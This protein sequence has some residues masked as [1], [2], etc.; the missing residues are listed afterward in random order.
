[1]IKYGSNFQPFVGKRDVKDKSD[2]DLTSEPETL[3][4]FR[5]TWELGIH[6]YLSYLRDRLLLAKDLLHISGSIFV[7]ISEEN[8]HLVRTLL[9]EIF[10]P[11]NFVS[12]I[13]YTT[14]G[15]FDSST[16]SRAGDYLLWYCKD[17]NKIKYRPLYQKK[18]SPVGGVSKYEQVE[19]RDGKRRP[20]TPEEKRGEKPLPEGS[21][22]F[23]LGDLTSQGASKSTV[24]QYKFGGR[25]HDC[26]PNNH[27]KTS[28]PEGMDKLAALKRITMTSTGKLAYV[29]YWDDFPY[30][31]YTNLWTDIGG[32]VQSRDKIYCVQ[33]GTSV[34]ER[35]ILMTTDPGDLIFDPTCGSGTTA[36][37]SE[38]WGRR[39][40]TCDTSRVAITLAKQRLMTAHYDYYKLARPSEGIDSGLVYKTAT[41][42]TL[43]SLA[44]GEAPDLVTL[45]DQPERDSKRARVTGPF[46]VEA[47][48]APVVQSLNDKLDL[49][50]NIADS[51]IG[52]AGETARQQDWREELLRSGIRGK[53]KRMIEFVRLEVLSGT[54]WL[55]LQ[56]EIKGTGERCFVS[57]GPEHAP[58]DQRQVE[59]AVQEAQKFVPRSAILIFAAFQFDPEAAKD[60]DELS[61]PGTE[62]LKAQMNPDLFT[63]DLKKKRS[64][65]ESFWLIG[66][67]DT[68]TQKIKSG[69]FK[70]MYEVVVRGFDYYNPQTGAIDSGDSGNIAMWMLDVDY[71][72]RSLFPRQVFFPNGG[73]NDGWKRLAKTL[74]SEIDEELI[75]QY[76]G[77]ISLPFEVGDYKRVAIK[78]V[79][80]RGI[81]SLRIIELQE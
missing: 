78:I 9:D 58:L 43:G 17:K 2:A 33:T 55:N 13:A 26:G 27:W 35:C 21:R 59:L 39:W 40:I 14:S 72:G 34:I 74:Q 22:L 24:R 56:G 70:G 51:S 45:Y 71:D 42:V 20:M 28:V 65:N 57:F 5:D 81:E 37:V 38:Q 63:M 11:E 7:Q 66:Q 77:T 68:R 30:T 23:R 32:S 79:D 10:G 80:D 29:R 44:N 47:V 16:L 64:A 75:E 31:S 15:G 50:H 61:W 52:R 67:P 60:I 4:A 73:A 1:G 18:S 19:E 69:D 3:R 49:T 25:T 36:V 76:T 46:T 48:P 6:S 54:R 12:M 53:N 8:I 62:I 41:R